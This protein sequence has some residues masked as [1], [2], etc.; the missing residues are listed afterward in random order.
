MGFKS[1]TN[2]NRYLIK[3]KFLA[4]ASQVEVISKSSQVLGRICTVFVPGLVRY[5]IGYLADQLHFVSGLMMDQLLFYLRFDFHLSSIWRKS[6]MC[7]DVS[8]TVL[9]GWGTN[10]AKHVKLNI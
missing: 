10:A 8:K 6:G 9:T 2:P 7:M 4:K 1:R 3:T 5:V